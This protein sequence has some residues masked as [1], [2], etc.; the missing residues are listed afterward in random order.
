[1]LLLDLLYALWSIVQQLHGL[2][3]YLFLAFL[4]LR[5]LLPRHFLLLLYS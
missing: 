2:L 4:M 1:M 3:V 5:P